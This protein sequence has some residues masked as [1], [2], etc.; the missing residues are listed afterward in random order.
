MSTGERLSFFYTR[1]SIS[2]K[3]PWTLVAVSDESYVTV[4]ILHVCIE[5]K[6]YENTPIQIRGTVESRYLDHAYLE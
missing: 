5:V 2:L 6:H 3:Y 1:V 4:K